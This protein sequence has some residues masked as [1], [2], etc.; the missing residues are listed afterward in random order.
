MQQG[1]CHSVGSIVIEEELIS[2]C[3]SRWHS[4]TINWQNVE[5]ES[6]SAENSFAPNGYKVCHRP[7]I[8]TPLMIPINKER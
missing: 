4:M 1:Q 7:V 6:G 3:G 5:A 2:S 8:R